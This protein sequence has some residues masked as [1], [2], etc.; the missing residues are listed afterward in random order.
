MNYEEI[1]KNH[2]LI[3]NLTLA[4]IEELQEK[5]AEQ[6]HKLKSKPPEYHMMCNPD[7]IQ[8]TKKK[9]ICTDTF[10]PRI[11]YN[12]SVNQEAVK[13]HKTLWKQYFIDNL[14]PKE[15]VDNHIGQLIFGWITDKL[16]TCYW[17]PD[18]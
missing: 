7:N 5:L 14:I 9:I 3:S 8:V 12:I 1:L 13:D 2:D 18:T 6:K 10:T 16:Y 4:E 11:V 15:Q 17:E